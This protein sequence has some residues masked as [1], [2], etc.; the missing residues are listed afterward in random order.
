MIDGITGLGTWFGLVTALCTMVITVFSL[1][2]AVTTRRS[3]K[4]AEQTHKQTIEIH[5]IV[6]QER[7]DMRR[8][9]TVLEAELTKHGIK[10]PEDQSQIVTEEGK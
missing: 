10:I 9:R 8:F 1:V 5:Q 6:N 2:I 3:K 4:T 7:T